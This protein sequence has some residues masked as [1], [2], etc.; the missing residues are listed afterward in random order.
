MFS[1]DPNWALAPWRV[2]KNESG[3]VILRGPNW[4]LVQFVG[5]LHQAEAPTK[6]AVKRFG[7]GAHHF[8]P[9]AFRRAFWSKCADN[10][11]A[12]RAG[13]FSSRAMSTTE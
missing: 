11:V 10:H 8:E 4:C 9:A 3:A 6:L 7:V 13:T 5:A 12:N 2:A 1:D